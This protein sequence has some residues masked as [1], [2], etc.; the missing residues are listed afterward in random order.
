M[1]PLSELT[2]TI[3]QAYELAIQRHREGDWEDAE[4]LCHQI[5]QHE[6]GHLAGLH[7]QGV[8]AT[9][10]FQRGN[11]LCL[12][13]DAR[14]AIPA[15]Q[16]ALTL[17]PNDPE[18]FNNLGNAFQQMHEPLNAIEAYRQALAIRPDYAGAWNN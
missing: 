7:L 3:Q 13:G 1:E 14:Q 17:R 4:S 15:Y 10:Y 12:A 18:I 11:E 9:S 8:L 6:P 2:L 5:L 16:R